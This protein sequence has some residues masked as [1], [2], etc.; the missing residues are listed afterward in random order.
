MELKR[1]YE[2]KEKYYNRFRKPYLIMRFKL[3]GEKYRIVNRSLEYQSFDLF[4]IDKLTNGHW[5]DF[6]GI[7]YGN[8]EAAKAKVRAMFGLTPIHEKLIL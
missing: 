2:L 7:C 6:A 8:I 4:C 1:K 5:N 3:N